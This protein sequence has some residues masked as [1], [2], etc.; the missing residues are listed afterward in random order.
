MSVASEEPGY[1]HPLFALRDKWDIIP[2]KARILGTPFII[3]HAIENNIPPESF[4]RSHLDSWC[5]ASVAAGKALEEVERQ[6]KHSPTRSRNS[7]C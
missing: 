7:S 5:S 4:S 1:K 6:R 2:V 3:R